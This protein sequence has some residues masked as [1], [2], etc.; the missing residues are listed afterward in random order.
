MAKRKKIQKNPLYDTDSITSFD[1]DEFNDEE[2][3]FSDGDIKPIGSLIASFNFQPH[4]SNNETTITTLPTDDN[5]HT[6]SKE[7]NTSNTTSV[8]A[9]HDNRKNPFPNGITPPIAGESLNIKRTYLLRASTIKKLN[10]LR[11]CHPDLTVCV[12][13]IVDEAISYYYDYIITQGNEQNSY[14]S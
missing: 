11:A 3:C 5:I 7:N 1:D 14:Y 10:E 13:S 8:T 2:I 4:T 12:S 9:L 6:N